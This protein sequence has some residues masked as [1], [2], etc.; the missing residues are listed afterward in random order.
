MRLE[1]RIHVKTLM[2]DEIAGAVLIDQRRIVSGCA[3]ADLVIEAV[4][5]NQLDTIIVVALTALGSI[6][7]CGI[8]IRS[9]RIF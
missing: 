9:G 6:S 3:F 1:L 4:V 5:A 7:S 2:V 8:H